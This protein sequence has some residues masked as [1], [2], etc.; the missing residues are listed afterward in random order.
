[1]EHPELKKIYETIW[2]AL[3]EAAR[4]IL[5]VHDFMRLTKALNLSIETS[6]ID[7]FIHRM[8]QLKKLRQLTFAPQRS[9]EWLDLRK[10]L[11]TASDLASAVGKGKFCSRSAL[12]TKKAEARRPPSAAAA[13]PATGATEVFKSPAMTWGVMFEPMIAR[14][15]SEQHDDIVLYDF[16]L[17]QHPTLSCFGASPDGITELGTMVEIK[18]PWRREIVQGDVPEHYYLQI[19]G[20]LSVCGLEKCDYF[21]VQM[22]DLETESRYYNATGATTTSGH[23]VILEIQASASD[24]TEYLYS[25]ARLTPPQ[26]YAWA[27]ETILKNPSMNLQRLRPWIVRTTNLVSVSFDPQLWATLEPQIRQFWAEVERLTDSP[28][29]DT[30][31]KKTIKKPRKK[32][33]YAYRDDDEV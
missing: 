1:M 29:A 9:Q 28:P 20:Q 13:T 33:T 11:L 21:E 22:E 27:K 24:T 5:T 19:Q 18:C 23:G 14:Y 30:S 12:L 25:P 8:A 10:N 17:I 32:Y 6:E 7:H 16:G 15:Y 26:A 31:D 2:R 4:D 3:P